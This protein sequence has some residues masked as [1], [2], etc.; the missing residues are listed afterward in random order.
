[1][2][3][4]AVLLA[5]AETWPLVTRITTHFPISVEELQAKRSLFPTDDRLLIAWILASNA[6]R[7]GEDPLGVF[8]TNNRYP[9]RRTLAFS[10]NFLG[11]TLPVWPVQ[12]I[13]DN[14]VLTSNIAL[15]FTLTVSAYGVTLLVHELT[16]SIAAALVA[17]TLATYAPVVWHQ[18][19]QLHVLTGM[20]A[21]LSFFALVRL[22]RTRAWRH[23][24]L[25]GALIAWQAWSSLHWGLFLALGLTS[26]VLVLLV[27]SAEARRVLPQLAFAAA[28]AGILIVPLV[29]P[30]ARVA[31]DMD[32][33]ERGFPL[34]LFVPWKALPPLAHP[35]DYIA[36]R[37]AHGGRPQGWL[38][39]IAPC[40][41][42]IAGLIAAAIVRRPRVISPPIVAALAAGVVINYWYACGPAA[43]RVGLPNLYGAVSAVPGL[44]FV[45]G[46]ARAVTYCSLMLAVLGGCGLAA[47]LRRIS[48]RIVRIAVVA[49]VIGL[50]VVE[51][52][53]Q[54]GETVA[55]PRRV[56]PVPPALAQLPTDCA[57]AELPAE[58]NAQTQGLFRS[59]THWR[60]LL[61][62][63]SGFFPVSVFV[64][65]LFLNQFPSDPALEYLRAAG[66]CAV[67]VTLGNRAGDNMIVASRTRG[68]SVSPLPEYNAAVVRFD[69]AP[70]D[71]PA[72]QRLDRTGWKI[73]EP[74]DGTSA[75]LDG[76][77][78]TL[79]TFDLEAS[80][81]PERVTI[82]LGR[83]SA[84]SGVEL[85]LGF[86]FRRYLW[87]YRI[88]GSEDGTRW[89]TLAEQQAVIP[90]FETY[91]ADPTRI[92]QRIRFP[93]A[94]VRFLRIGPYRKPPKRDVAP[95]MGFKWWSIAELDVLGQ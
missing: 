54:P 87:T 7:L 56:L 51:A 76:S 62:G 92:V 72:G 22:L 59:T 8:D 3:A 86:H 11:I 61:N 73:L 90:P 29:I 47:V 94:T 50:G 10:E 42:I 4:F 35:Y 1:M 69:P 66:A 12:A 31:H 65:N 6:R 83:E 78:E 36:D 16:G 68:L 52:G 74:A 45:R 64:E 34:F 25:L 46:P 43:T 80:A 57:I 70:P 2:L 20:T 27:S 85:S 40:L 24:V 23:A 82:D 15:L 91:R 28:L 38:T 81:E 58:W 77:L 49:I 53:W 26:A 32:V 18:I 88:E 9:F 71:P 14:P 60:P 79:R 37:L 89:S 5:L 44:S 21:A 19:E 39:M 41:A 33:S 55:A 13:W 93:P 84:V 95:D 30:Y 48:S 63:R 67:V 75:M 17:A